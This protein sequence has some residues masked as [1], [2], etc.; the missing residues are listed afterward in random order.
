MSHHYSGP[1]FGSPTGMPAWISPTC[2]LSQSLEM[3]VSR[4]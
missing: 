1:D 4:S 3:L 2:M